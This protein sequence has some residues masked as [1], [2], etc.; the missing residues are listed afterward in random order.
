M[1]TIKK[2]EKKRLTFVFIVLCFMLS[3]VLIKAF[4]I[5][6]VQN[7]KLIAIADAQ[8]LRSEKVY[9]N[10]G[11]IFDRNGDP[12]AINVQTYSLFTIPRHVKNSQKTYKQLSK[13]G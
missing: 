11:N 3:A 8:T 4:T 10:R 9:P 5:Q 1:S 6:V 2:T 13:V 7:K 12:L